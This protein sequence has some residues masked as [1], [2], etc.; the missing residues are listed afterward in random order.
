M[1]VSA[2]KAIVLAED[3]AD[4]SWIPKIDM[5]FET[6]EKAYQFYCLYGKEMGFG[7]R[8]HL[9]KRRSSGIVY[10]RVFCCYKEGF[11][12]TL[13]PGKRPRPD[14]RT[15]CRAHITVRLMDD[16]RFRISDFEPNH[17]HDL[18]TANILVEESDKTNDSV[19][20]E[21]VSAKNMA[22]AVI[23]RPSPKTYLPS[24]SMNATRA[25]GTGAVMRYV[26]RGV[27]ESR[28]TRSLVAA[29]ENNIPAGEHWVPKIDMEFEDDQ[30]AYQFYVNYANGV[31]FSVRKH[32]V[33]RRASGVIYSREYV[34][35]KEGF[36]KKL[37][38]EEGRNPKLYDRTGCPAGMT[39]KIAKNGKYRVSKFEPKHNHGL[40]VPSK[41]HMLK[42]RWRRR[43]INP[44]PDLMQ[45]EEGPGVEPEPSDEHVDRQVENFRQPFIS[46][47]YKNYIPSKRTNSMRLGDVGALMQ[48]LQEKQSCDPSFYYAVQLD[49]YD[50]VTNV[51]WADAKSMVDFEFF[52]D[53]LCLDT[54]SKLSDHGRPFAPFVGVNHHKQPIVF[55]A[56]LLYDYSKES[57]KWLFETFK[58]AMCGKQPKVILTDRSS[59][60]HDAVTMVWPGTTHRVCVWHIY[61]DAEKHLNF[62]F[63]ASTTFAKDFSRCLFDCEDE[64]EFLFEWKTMLQ[65]YDLHKNDWLKKLYDDRE[66]W[67]LPYGRQTFCADIKTTLVRENMSSMLKEYLNRDLDLLDFFKHY[68]RI[69]DEQRTS[70]IQ[71]DLSVHQNISQFPSSRMLRQAAN[72]YTPA[73]F[74]MFQM[75]FELSMDCMVYSCGQVGTTFE[76][77]VTTENPREYTVRFD[78]S[79]GTVECSCKRFEFTGIQCRHVLKTLDIINV[80]ELPPQY[81][82]KRWTPNAKV[83]NLRDNCELAINNDVSS[84]LARRYSSLCCIFNKIAVRAAESVDTY[85]FIESLSDRLMDQVYQILQT[86]PPEDPDV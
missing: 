5:V 73:V 21:T 77:K 19:A 61:N 36:R 26:Q 15:G 43:A 59:E 23:P 79:N 1:A 49:P 67:A 30:E 60:V 34:C 13:K 12:R 31:G 82:M 14:R 64:E 63:Q 68:D 51:L 52:G 56:A 58:T 27:Q 72:A 83:M 62:V 38:G 50:Q 81:I 66:K 16:G 74:K 22:R 54:T 76:Y 85:T 32:L 7:V 48:Y 40:I 9:V 18:V 20:T 3:A 37:E 25:G 80:K 53:I 41:A 75:E 84:A 69:V 70:E 17:N 8:K 55:A 10:S 2:E 71:A 78:S 29:S 33:K 6:D 28:P 47:G 11:C 42:W 86:R 45:I 44:P 65:D 35:H 24:K 39:I 46:D 57:Y 4:E